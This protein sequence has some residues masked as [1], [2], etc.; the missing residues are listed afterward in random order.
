MPIVYPLGAVN[1]SL[2]ASFSYVGSSYKPSHPSLSLSLGVHCIQDCFKKKGGRKQKYIKSQK[3]KASHEE[4]SNL[5]RVTVQPKLVVGYWE[6]VP[7]ESG[8]G[9][10]SDKYTDTVTN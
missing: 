8:S 6:L 4:H 1:V 10:S 7:M 5:M 9:N 3:E 2:L